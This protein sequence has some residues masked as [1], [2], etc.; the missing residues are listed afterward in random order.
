MVRVPSA[1]KPLMS[2]RCLAFLAACAIGL[3][4]GQPR[5]EALGRA[6]TLDDPSGHA[7]D[8]LHAALRAARDGTGRAR[9]TFYGDSHTS[10]DLYTGPLRHSLQRRF[11][12]GGPGLVM[13]VHPFPCHDHSDVVISHEGPWSTVVVKGRH[14]PRDAY[15]PAGYAVESRAKAWGRVDLRANATKGSATVSTEVLSLDQPGGGHL[16]V[17]V[18]GRRASRLSTVA[19]TRQLGARRVEGASRRIEVRAEGDGPVRLFGL[20][21]ERDGPGVVVDALGI[22]GAKARE[23]L[24]WD[25][26]V[27]RAAL[28]RLAPDLVVLEYGTNESGGDLQ[29]MPRY[30][31]DLSAVVQRLRR[32]RPS[33]SCLLVG[34]SE[35]P[36][37]RANGT[38]GPRAR[39]SEITE[40]QRRVAQAQGCAFF[41][42]LAF[43]GGPGAMVQWVGHDPPLALT[44]HVHFTDEGY[45]RLA[46]ALESALLQGF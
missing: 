18:D 11:G 28:D 22:P 16:E 37:R 40:V 13:P 43:M 35:W 8:Q 27:Q 17:L 10:E 42:T 23:Q 2:S 6:I 5:A 34:P 19:K 3:C 15:G 44:D 25:E 31:Q 45:R 39:T 29:A 9:L 38:Y 7:L 4:P 26:A 41:D 32:L 1:F 24:V 36:V 12:D 30:E 14:R 21:L 20:S 33:A 46:L